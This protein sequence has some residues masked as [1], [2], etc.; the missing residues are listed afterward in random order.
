MASFLMTL[1]HSV[2]CKRYEKM[3]EMVG[4][5]GTLCNTAHE[6]RQAVE[7]AVGR[8]FSTPQ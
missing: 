7:Q 5:Q 6:V 3:M 2:M 1:F 4:G 8:S